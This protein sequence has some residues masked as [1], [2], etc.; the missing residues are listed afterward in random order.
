M[1][2]VYSRHSKSTRAACKCENQFPAEYANFWKVDFLTY[3]YGFS[4]AQC[5][6]VHNVIYYTPIGTHVYIYI[7]IFTRAIVVF[8]AVL[9]AFYFIFYPVTVRCSREESNWFLSS[10]LERATT[11]KGANEEKEKYNT[12]SVFP[13]T[14]TAADTLS[15]GL[16]FPRRNDDDNASMLHGYVIDFLFFVI[17]FFSFSSVIFIFSPNGYSHTDCAKMCV[18]KRRRVS[19]VRQLSVKASIS[20]NSWNLPQP[21][22]RIWVRIR[23]RD[24]F[25]DIEL[26]IALNR[27]GLSKT[28]WLLRNPKEDF[29]DDKIGFLY[30]FLNGAVIILGNFTNSE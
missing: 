23:Q 19:A 24:C 21:R 2:T 18:C 4:P 8:Y 26:Q 22:C 28:Y 25:E 11:D 3:T 30:L 27:L 17:F 6:Y 9:H 13:W 12:N 1:N 7:Y 15:R 14:T 29:N 16:L 10:G 20:S 5:V